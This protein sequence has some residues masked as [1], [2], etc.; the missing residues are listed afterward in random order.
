[1]D[2]LRKLG[3]RIEKI[4]YAVVLV[5]SFFA[6]GVISFKLWRV[7]HPDAPTWSFFFSHHNN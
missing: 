1:M 7:Q 5:T 3:K 4:F 2:Q 6:L